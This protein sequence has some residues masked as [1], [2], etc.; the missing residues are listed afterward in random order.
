M[1]IKVITTHVHW[2]HIGG[3]G[4]FAEIYVH[5]LEQDW[6]LRGIPGL[7]MEVIKKNLVKD[8]PLTILNQL[9]FKIEQYKLYQ[10]KPTGVLQDNDVIDLGNRK[11]QIIHTP[12]HSP[13]HIC[14]YE[15]ER[16]Y[17]FTGD[18]IYQGS[19]FAFYPTTDPVAFVDSVA[20]IC[21]IKYVDK[22]LPGHYKLP[23]TQDFLGAVNEACQELQAKGLAKHGSG[24]HDYGDFKIHF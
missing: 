21:S 11:L 9:N 8:V 18:L 5:E 16:G 3:H 19:L 4:D 6:L 12:G 1:P 10:G 20:K 14:I 13:G 15:P 22:V 7:S 17:L 2:D 24:V 23:L